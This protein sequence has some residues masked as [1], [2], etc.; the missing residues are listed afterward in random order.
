[1][2][3]LKEYVIIVV[4]LIIVFAINCITGKNL[5][6][7][8]RWMRDGIISIEN[9]MSENDEEGAK[10]EFYELE[11]KW[12]KETDKLSF[13]V[14]HNELEKV[15]D[16]IAIVEAN[17]NTKDNDKIIETI[18]ELKFMLEHIEDKNKLKWKNIF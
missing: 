9:K 13:F 14:E 12:K 8:I 18:S 11:D 7:S 6:S 16:D 1:M 15:S 2:R 10:N 3:F 5:E 4:I 17:F